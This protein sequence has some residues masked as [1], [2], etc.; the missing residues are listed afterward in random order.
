M[1]GH[2]ASLWCYSVPAVLCQ[3]NNGTIDKSV[4]AL[5]GSRRGL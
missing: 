2:L 4:A 3:I 1:I 5:L